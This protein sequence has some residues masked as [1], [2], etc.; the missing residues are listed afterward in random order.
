MNLVNNN[1]HIYFSTRN[2][3]VLVAHALRNVL[4]GRV[5]SRIENG[6]LGHYS[7]PKTAAHLS[8]LHKL[9][10]HLNLKMIVNEQFIWSFIDPK[11]DDHINY[12]FPARDYIIHLFPKEN[13]SPQMLKSKAD[14]LKEW[15]PRILK[16]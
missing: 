6:P 8:A 5:F 1:Y 12:D 10:N 2:E 16:K 7:F 11:E 15:A 14:T 9:I 4:G 3:A 13:M